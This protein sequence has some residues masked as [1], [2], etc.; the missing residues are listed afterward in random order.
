ME[1]IASDTSGVEGFLRDN[2]PG[3]LHVDPLA[4]DSENKPLKSYSGMYLHSY[5]LIQGAS[6]GERLS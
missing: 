6:D 5:R 4:E 1:L 2:F 3:S